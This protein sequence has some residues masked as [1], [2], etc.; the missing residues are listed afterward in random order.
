MNKIKK[1]KVYKVIFELKSPLSIGSGNNDQTDRDIIKNS[2]GIPYIPGSA[3][4]GIGRE[5]ARKLMK[6]L[7][8]EEQEKKYFGDISNSE[9]ERNIPSRII[10]YDG[11]IDGDIYYISNRDSVELDQWKTAIKRHKFDMEILE[12]GIK[13]VT[14]IE[15][16]YF[17]DD[18]QDIA[19]DILKCW[20]SNTIYMGTKTMRGYG[21]LKTEKVLVKEFDF[22]DEESLVKWL[23]F[24][25]YTDLWKE[26]GEVKT[27]NNDQSDRIE[28]KLQ[29]KQVGGIFIRRYTTKAAEEKNQMVPDYEQLTVRVGDKELP[30]IPGTSWAG[31][32]RHRMI[33]LNEKCDREELW[34]TANPENKCKSSIRFSETI[35]YGAKEK[36]ISRNSI[37][38]FSGGTADTALFTEKT[39]YG[40]ETELIISVDRKVDAS[41]KYT[42][43]ATIADLHNGFLAV[44]GLTSVGRGL[45]KIKSVNGLPIS[46]NIYKDVLKVLNTSGTEV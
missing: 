14:Y 43:A 25:M 3:I 30:T 41:V 44:G 10:F 1:K 28:V 19:M 7:G 40:G 8:R 31:A 4:A 32:F 12:P 24:D 26:A 46:E 33:L 22:T 45:F 17:E 9:K 6:D 37:D 18:D 34:G 21:E 36:Q 23:D 16:S 39:Y 38:R 13:I 2:L 27:G 35:L 20:L 5:T 42:L 11:K 29:L 15:Q